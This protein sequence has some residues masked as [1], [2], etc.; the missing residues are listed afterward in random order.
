MAE[1]DTSIYAGA[2]AGRGADIVRSLLDDLDKYYADREVARKPT[3][4]ATEAPHGKGR[5]TVRATP[6]APAVPSGITV[7]AGVNPAGLM[8]PIGGSNAG[9]TWDKVPGSGGSPGSRNFGGSRAGKLHTAVDIPAAVGDPVF[10]VMPGGRIARAGW[11]P[12]YGN[13]V[14]IRYPDGTVHRAAHLSKLGSYKVGQEVPVGAVIG[15]SGYSGNASKN[16]PHVHYEVIRASAYDKYEGRPPGREPSLASLEADRF[17]PRTYWAAKGA[18]VA[19]ADIKNPKKEGTGNIFT[20]YANRKDAE[21]ALDDL[22]GA[23]KD[24]A[25]AKA[26]SARDAAAAEAGVTPKVTSPVTALAYAGDP[27]TELVGTEMPKR[28]FRKGDSGDDIRPFQSMLADLGY[29]DGVIDG[30]YGRRTRKA[31]VK[32]QKD[33]KLK[34][35]GIVGVG[36]KSETGPALFRAWSSRKGLSEAPP[37]GAETV[38]AGA[39]LSEPSTVSPVAAGAGANKPAPLTA[40]T[41]PVQTFDVK[42]GVRPP[43]APIPVTVRIDPGEVSDYTGA[44]RNPELPSNRAPEPT[45]P[46]PAPLAAPGFNHST[47]REYDPAEM[48]IA[49]AYRRIDA[50]ARK[51]AEEFARPPGDLSHPV[52]SR[53]EFDLRFDPVAPAPIGRKAFDDRFADPAPDPRFTD[54]NFQPARPGGAALQDAAQR[55]APVAPETRV[56]PAIAKDRVGGDGLIEHPPIMP[57]IPSDVRGDAAA[58]APAIRVADAAGTMP[59]DAFDAFF[60]ATPTPDFGPTLPEAKDDAFS[61]FFDLTPAA[62]DAVDM[63]PDTGLPHDFDAMAPKGRPAGPV[64]SGAPDMGVIAR[65]TIRSLPIVGPWLDEAAEAS[66]AWA[67]SIIKGTKYEDEL[68]AAKAAHAEAEKASPNSAEFGKG[69]GPVLGFLGMAAAAPTAFGLSGGTMASRMGASALTNMGIGGIDA[70]MRGDTD[71]VSAAMAAGTLGLFF[72]GVGGAVGRLL[73]SGVRRDIAALAEKA[74]NKFG[75]ALDASQ[76]SSNPMV[77][78]AHGVVEGMPLSGGTAAK[79]DRQVAFNRAVARTFGETADH[80]SLDTVANA[81]TRL[82]KEF[83]DVLAKIPELPADPELANGVIRLLGEIPQTL[84]AEQAAPIKRQLDSLVKMIQDNGNKI[85]SEAF[86]NLIKH[87]S[88]LDKLMNNSDSSIAG[89]AHDIRDL[90]DDWVERYAPADVLDKWK[91]AKTQYKALKTVDK[92]AAKNPAGDVSPAGLMTPVM[93]NYPDF[94][95]GGGGDLAELSRIGQAFLKEP[96]SSGTSERQQVYGILGAAGRALEPLLMGGGAAAY[97]GGHIPLTAAAIAAPFIAGRTARRIISSKLLRNHL[98]ESALNGP[99]NLARRLPLAVP[100]AGQLASPALNHLIRG[101]HGDDPRSGAA[102]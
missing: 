100:A 65:S 82:G 80:V 62:P 27:T 84:K 102:R 55:A 97:T 40:A 53:T 70:V 32:F 57:R 77:R 54:D 14:D 64:E 30:E 17:D 93:H 36:P 31:V 91:L 74:I 11:G 39:G 46:A 43:V 20:D 86:Q 47:E 2:D 79:A 10:A 63:N 9:M 23:D 94:I 58:V 15:L 19:M 24:A 99:G 8:F 26:K 16:F 56:P 101:F 41:T 98:I 45:A 42:A 85:S 72:P 69:T 78:F 81:Y 96:P 89:Y 66:S 25:L 52:P 33:N 5:G 29:Y 7:E 83:D 95:K 4:R 92:L 87:N 6:A 37:P 38:E 59:K 35:D 60:G 22:K 73:S 13:V 67:R 68:A 18:G 48:V 88:P 49:N 50:E 3:P 28:A 34:P 12:G 75:I 76:L 90:L 71:P 21:L 61:T 44:P 1:V 51:S